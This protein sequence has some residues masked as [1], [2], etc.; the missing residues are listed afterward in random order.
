MYFVLFS[1]Y[2]WK[3]CLRKQEYVFASEIASLVV[4]RAYVIDGNHKGV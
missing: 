4:E 2:V 1:T 3:T